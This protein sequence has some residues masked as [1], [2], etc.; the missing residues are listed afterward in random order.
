M[1]SKFKRCTWEERLCDPARRL[2]QP[3]LCMQMLSNRPAGL[4][5]E[6]RGGGSSGHADVAQYAYSSVM[7][8]FDKRGNGAE[9]AARHHCPYLELKFRRAFALRQLSLF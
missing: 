8:I 4:P 5:Q 2:N 9:N 7:Q 6:G 3:R 1:S